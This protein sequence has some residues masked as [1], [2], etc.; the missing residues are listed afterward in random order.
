MNAINFHSLRDREHKVY[1]QRES[2]LAVTSHHFLSVIFNQ[3]ALEV[4]AV[5]FPLPCNC[6]TDEQLDRT[7]EFLSSSPTRM[8]LQ[9]LQKL[10]PESIIAGGR[11]GDLAH[12]QQQ[13]LVGG[14]SAL[15]LIIVKG[16][17]HM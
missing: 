4:M 17:R 12:I 9:G 14:L 1:M 13:L 3:P 6:Q 7:P 15:K 10:L 5:A 11:R 2:S 16:T 8:K